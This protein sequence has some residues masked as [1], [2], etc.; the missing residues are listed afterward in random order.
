ME[1]PAIFRI[2]LQVFLVSNAFSWRI[3]KSSATPQ[4]DT[5]QTVSGN[6]KSFVV[7]C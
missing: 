2:Y 1:S 7:V 6:L 3:V 5:I 4:N